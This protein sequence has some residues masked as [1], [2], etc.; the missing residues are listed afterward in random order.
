MKNVDALHLCFRNKRATE[1][2]VETFLEKFPDSKVSLIVD[3]GGLDFSYLENKHI[4]VEHYENYNMGGTGPN[5]Y[6]DSKRMTALFHRIKKAIDFLD[7]K[8]VLIL[9]DDVLVTR[10]FDP[11]EAGEFVLAGVGN[12]CFS[13]DFKSMYPDAKLSYWGIGG[14]SMISRCHYLELYDDIIDHI[15]KHH[16]ANVEKFRA[17]GAF[18]CCSTFHFARHGF[19]IKHAKWLTDGSVVHPWKNLYPPGWRNDNQVE[20]DDQ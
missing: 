10:S 15:D 18:D 4:K 1:K 20:W 7:K 16:D 9:E 8:Y 5:A 14:G 17:I 6:L 13:E 3:K 19:E 11:E 2:I 12:N